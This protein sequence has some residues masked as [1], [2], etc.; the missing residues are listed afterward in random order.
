MHVP[1]YPP[2]LPYLLQSQN[3]LKVC[4]SK[5]VKFFV[6]YCKSFSCMFQ[7][8]IPSPLEE[9]FPTIRSYIT[10]LLYTDFIIPT[11]NSTN[12]YIIIF[13]V[14]PCILVLS[15]LLFIQLNAQL[16]CSKRMLKFTLKALLH[17]SV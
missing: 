16:D 6:L 13:T 10:P 17:V 7:L 12:G 2:T 11:I 1:A 3:I 8:Q 9:Y 14:V 15:S 4:T 5:T